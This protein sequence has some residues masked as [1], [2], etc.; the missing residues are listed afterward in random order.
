M[1]QE[2]WKYSPFGEDS[3]FH[4]NFDKNQKNK[5]K[6][7]PK[8][9]PKE[10][11][12]ALIVLDNEYRSQFDDTKNDLWTIFHISDLAD[13]KKVKES[14]LDKYIFNNLCLN[15]HGNTYSD[16]KLPITTILN[17]EY[18]IHI[19]SVIKEVKKEISSISDLD[20]SYFLD[21]ENKSKEMFN[22]GNGLKPNCL[23]AYFSLKFL[24]ANISNNGNYFS[25]ACDGADNMNLVKKLSEFTS[26]NIS[27]FSNSNMTIGRRAP[28]T[29]AKIPYEGCILNSFLTSESNWKD[30]SGWHC[31]KTD[32]K[33]GGKNTVTKQDLWLYSTGK[34]IYE[35][36]TRK[37]KLEDTQ[38][39]YE[40]SAQTYFSKSFEKAYT[41][42]YTKEEYDKYCEPLKKKPFEF[43]P[44]KKISN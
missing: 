39:R 42:K 13:Y 25:L 1:E 26:N 43:V 28:S 29:Y 5:R 4:P 21:L 35:L 19:E 22:K 30:D 36:K 6:Q 3:L 20:D 15:H 9:L 16:S 40:T 27:I 34:K 11:I 8:P 2:Y 18:I 38:T 23:R 32:G 24:I 33:G 7:N 17:I 10:Y 31:Y 44:P 12:N 14:I 37:K 41:K